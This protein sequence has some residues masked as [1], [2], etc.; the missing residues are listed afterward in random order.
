MPLSRHSG[1]NFSMKILDKM[2]FFIKQFI[3]G[4]KPC[5]QTHLNPFVLQKGRW[6]S[7]FLSEREQDI[8]I[9]HS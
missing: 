3:Y 5:K 8:D 4:F 6:N 9:K 2:E 1:E 7:R